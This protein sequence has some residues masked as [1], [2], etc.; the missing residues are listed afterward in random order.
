MTNR[1]ASRE[2]KQFLYEHG[3]SR[4]LFD[5]DDGRYLIADTYMSTQFAVDLKGFVEKWIKSNGIPDQ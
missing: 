4:I 1:T 5:D 2:V 3:G